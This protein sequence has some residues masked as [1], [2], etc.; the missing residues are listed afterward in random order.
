MDHDAE[1]ANRY[2][3]GFGAFL[4]FGAL[5]GIILFLAFTKRS[6]EKNSVCSLSSS[7]HSDGCKFNMV[8]TTEGGV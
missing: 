6:E 7:C 1:G 3:S 5:P 8:E 4:F 2:L